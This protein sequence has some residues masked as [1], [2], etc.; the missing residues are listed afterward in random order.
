MIARSD[1]IRVEILLFV[2]PFTFLVTLEQLPDFDD[3][4]RGLSLI[5][6]PG[7][8]VRDLVNVAEM[9][10]ESESERLLPKQVDHILQDIRSVLAE[11]LMRGKGIDLVTMVPSR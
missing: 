3:A 4:S 6:A 10:H 1:R 5:D 2:R 9:H 7:K 8:H 11:E